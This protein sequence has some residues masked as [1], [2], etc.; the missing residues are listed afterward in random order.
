MFRMHIIHRRRHVENF[1][2]TKHTHT[3]T[4]TRKERIRHTNVRVHICAL[5][6]DFLTPRRH[7][8]DTLR[9]FVTSSAVRNTKYLLLLGE[10]VLATDNCPVRNAHYFQFISFIILYTSRFLIKKII[11]KRCIIIIE[12]NNNRR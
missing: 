4:R 11:T 2:R 3:R 6:G 7:S 10:S 8:I 1:T 9:G 5:Y 12:N